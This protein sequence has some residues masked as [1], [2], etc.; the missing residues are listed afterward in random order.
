MTKFK[1]STDA[2]TG[3]TDVWLDGRKIGSVYLAEGQWRWSVR[4]RSGDTFRTMADAAMW[5]AERR[6]S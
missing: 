2:L 4:G 3:D 6:E 5:L 1:Y